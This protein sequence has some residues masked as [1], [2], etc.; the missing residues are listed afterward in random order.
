M[1]LRQMIWIMSVWLFIGILDALN[2]Y[3]VA[4]GVLL[5][6]NTNYNWPR[7]LSVKIITAL[8][9]GIFSSIILLFFLRDQLRGKSFGFALLLN[10]L[11]ISLLNFGIIALAHHYLLAIDY[12][13]TP[14]FFKSLVLWTIVT[15]LTI[16][17]LHVNDKYG[18]G[19]L[20]KLL[21]GRY[22]Y[23]REEERIFMFVDLKSSTTIAEELGHV[24]FFNLLNDFFRDLTDPIINTN[25][26][27]Y[28]YVGDEIVISWTMSNGLRKAN[29]IRC[30]YSM[31][32]A[33]QRNADD[34]HLKYNLVPEFKAGL[35]CGL[36]TVGEI[37][38]IKKDIVFSG[39]VVNTTARMESLCNLYGV[40]LLTSKILLNK[41]QLPPNDYPTVRM[42]IIELKGKIEKV[43]L[44]TF[45][46]NLLIDNPRPVFST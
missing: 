15:I 20:L 21:L 25:G 34:Y 16:V 11:V 6:A 28:Q 41:L 46:D 45:A 23:P 7:F 29:C 5:E 40:R 9:A 26:E 38:I 12:S 37:G 8:F 19:V 1:L 10:S 32:E 22:H 24:Q 44:F 30:F 31:L 27:I 14:F 2:T 39:D 13:R 3:A 43:E 4:E 17:F 42:G 18:P 33:I 35:H 36:V